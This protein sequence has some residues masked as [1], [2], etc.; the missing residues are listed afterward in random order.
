MDMDQDSPRLVI[1]VIK[2]T[3]Q[4]DNTIQPDANFTIYFLRIF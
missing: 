1:E 2:A 3:K 4:K